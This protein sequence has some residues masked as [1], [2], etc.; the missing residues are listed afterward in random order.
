MKFR[1]TTL[2]AGLLAIALA[3]VGST[4]TAQAD[5]VRTDKRNVVLAWN[6]DIVTGL[7][8][9]EVAVYAISPSMAAINLESADQPGFVMDLPIYKEHPRRAKTSGGVLLINVA[10]QSVVNLAQM[11]VNTETQTIS[12][13]ASFSSEGF[14][15]RIPVFTYSG[16]RVKG[17]NVTGARLTLDKGLANKLNSALKAT[18]FTEEMT[19]GTVDIARRGR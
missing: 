4:A 9:E 6:L 2:L 3:L 14:Q 11:T 19:L 7:I 8:Q 5:S 15:G 10:T 16:G 18:I 13:I 1:Q 17:P 12:A